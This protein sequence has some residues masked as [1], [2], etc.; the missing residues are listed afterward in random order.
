MNLTIHVEFGINKVAQ[1]FSGKI[2]EY[3]G[4]AKIILKCILQDLT[5]SQR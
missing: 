3:L 1:G 4:E 5:F 2:F